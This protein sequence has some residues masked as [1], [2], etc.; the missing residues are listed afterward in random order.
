MGDGCTALT[1]QESSRIDEVIFPIGV[2]E[3]VLPDRPSRAGGVDK[4]VIL[5]VDAD[6]GVFLSALIKEQEIAC[7]QVIA[8]Y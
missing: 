8:Y 6:M 2:L 7:L 3:A 5:Q 1:L 4:G